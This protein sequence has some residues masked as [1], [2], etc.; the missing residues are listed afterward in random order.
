MNFFLQEKHKCV[1]IILYFFIFLIAKLSQLS[2]PLNSEHYAVMLGSKLTSKNTWER[3]KMENP[4]LAKTVYLLLAK[5]CWNMQ[6]HLL[7]SQKYPCKSQGR[8]CTSVLLVSLLC[9]VHLW[10]CIPTVWVPSKPVPGVL[11]PQQR[12]FHHLLQSVPKHHSKSSWKI[13]YSF[14]QWK[15]D[16]F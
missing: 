16:N 3:K 8:I 10:F 12:Q 4:P 6:C 2:V 11:S 14:L 13:T 1:F 5:K 7:A 15:V 9:K